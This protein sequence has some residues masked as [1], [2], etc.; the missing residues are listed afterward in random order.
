MRDIDPLKKRV[1][2]AERQLAATETARDRES[3]ALME[4]WRQIQTRF[5]DQEQEI[6]R[7]RARVEALV[8]KNEE[9]ALIVNDLLATI[10]SS[11]D[12]SRDQTVPHL[13]T[14]A[15]DLLA[16]EPSSALMAEAAA[17]LDDE[18]P[19]ED[20]LDLHDNE[21]IVRSDADDVLVLDTEA[22]DEEP[23]PEEDASGDDPDFSLSPGIRSLISRIEQTS[24]SAGAVA[25]D[26]DDDI[27][28]D[29]LSRDL[30]EIETLR[31]ELSGLRDR[32]SASGGS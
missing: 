24:P 16:T 14:L 17:T 15:K 31:D 12:Q 11:I 23:A 3:Q 28:E 7:Y 22:F 8:A 29:G 9:L 27:D 26:D 25:A 6:A 20:M 19:L 4:M 5:A 10:E 30:R 13:A 21:D 18:P 1:E 32:M 2:T